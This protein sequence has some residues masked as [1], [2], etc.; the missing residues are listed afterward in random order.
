MNQYKGYDGRVR[1]RAPRSASLAV[2]RSPLAVRRPAYTLVE[3]L[4][5][6]TL[7]LVLMFAVVQIFAMLGDSVSDS[8]A[9]LEMNDRLRA[10]KT[11]LQLDLGGLTVVPL[12]PRGEDNDGYLEIIEGPVGVTTPLASVAQNQVDGGVDTTV[13]DFD[14]VLLFTTRDTRTPFVAGGVQSDIAEV[15]W[16][17]RGNKLYRRM[18]PLPSNRTLAQLTRR[19][20]RNNQ[21]AGRGGSFP[22]AVTP[23]SSEARD[24]W[25]PEANNAGA[26][27]L[28]WADDDVILNNVIGFDVKVFDP[29]VGDYVD[30]GY[31]GSQ[32]WAN[33]SSTFSHVGHPD[34][35]LMRVYDTW[36]T[37]YLINPNDSEPSSISPPYPSALRG[38]QVKIRVFEPDSRHIREVTVIQDF[39]PR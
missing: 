11:R 9:L 31:A 32:T 39:L 8:R 17:V 27:S 30:L 6:T 10:A 16:F 33:R 18:R 14:D 15:A 4:V 23:P 21:V 2:G 5:A 7:T 3:I 1:T 13:A 38:I 29:V 35:G 34:A 36:S 19:D 28:M 25:T 37:S 22:F 26:G 12:P 20:Y 24:F